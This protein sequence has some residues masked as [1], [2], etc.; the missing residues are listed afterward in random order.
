MHWDP[1]PYWDWEHYMKLIGAPI[2]GKARPGREPSRKP[3]RV[4]D[5]VTVKPGFDDNAQPIV[6]C[7]EA[8]VPC[9]EQGSNFVYLYQSDDTASPLV[10]DEGL[11]PG[12]T[13]STTQVS[14]IGARAA[15]GQ[16]LVVAQ[17]EGRRWLGVWWLGR[18]AWL[19]NPKGDRTVVRARGRKVRKVVPR[20][21]LEEVPV[22]GRAY[23]EESAYPK[24][25]PYQAIAPLQY[26]IRA[27]QAYSL[28]DARVA[29]D[30]YYAKVFD[31]SLPLNRTVVS[32]KDRY[33]QVWLG[34][35]MAFVRADDVR[36]VRR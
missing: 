12:A 27:G 7:D 21:G 23:P 3:I 24:Q 1:G 5:V 28:A 20:P 10:R 30:Y 34:H 18:I 29:T 33:Y 32:G 6:G 25:I 14:D 16:E 26:T 13:E 31:D 8:G 19:E 4:G 9:E 36:L 15:A 2:G 11:R 17:T 22:Y 35:R